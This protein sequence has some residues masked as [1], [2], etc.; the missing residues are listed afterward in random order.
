[1][2]DDNDEIEHDFTLPIATIPPETYSETRL[3]LS[4][5]CTPIRSANPGD[6]V[7]A[8][9]S[10]VDGR[11]MSCAQPLTEFI[12]CTG[13]A[14]SPFQK[15]AFSSMPK[16]QQARLALVSMRLQSKLPASYE[17]CESLSPLRNPGNYNNYF[18]VYATPDFMLATLQHYRD[19]VFEG[20]F[21]GEPVD[22]DILDC[23]F[24]ALLPRTIHSSHEAIDTA[25]VIDDL[26]SLAD[27]LLHVPHDDDADQKIPLHRPDLNALIATKT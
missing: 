24:R 1:M 20:T 2:Y 23:A 19:E 16:A 12:T 6:V 18:E 14:S 10:Y 22:Q 7:A 4:E 8:V 27:G 26:M 3:A 25:H 13:D 11:D 15:T 17:I 9:F 21:I 5:L